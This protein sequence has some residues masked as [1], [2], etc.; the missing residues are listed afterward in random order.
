[1]GTRR[2]EMTGTLVGLV[3]IALLGLALADWLFYQT[4]AVS[5]VFR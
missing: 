5:L 1:M 3:G 4:F 2:I